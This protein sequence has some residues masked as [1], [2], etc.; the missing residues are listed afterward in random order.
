M[1]RLRG[2]LV[3]FNSIVVAL[4]VATVVIVMSGGNSGE[5][6]RV[7]FEGA[8]GSGPAML[9][10]LAKAT[11]LLFAGLGVSIALRAGLFN[12]GVEGQLLV[13]ALSASVA[14]YAIH[15]L[16]AVVHVALVLAAGAAGGA[17]WAFVPGI[18]KAWRGAHEV[19]V[20]IMMNH[21]AILLT[22]WLVNGPLR[23]ASRITNPNA[24]PRTPMM[25]PTAHL[26]TMPGGS[27]FSAG[28]LIALLCAVLVA[29]LIHGTAPGFEI[30]AVGLGREAAR[31]A[32]ISVGRT[33]I[34]AMCL[35]GGLAGMAG[36]VEAVVV[37]HRFIAQFSPGYGF[38]SIAVALLGGLNSLGV[39]LSS[40]LFGGLYTGAN[41]MEILSGTPRQITGVIQAVVI[42]AAASR[43]FSRRPE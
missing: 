16:P 30:R 5:S 26:W 18:L 4:A 41:T 20:T 29:W 11:P 6:L 23:D 35:S 39:T 10:T 12:I 28:F 2:L 40:I 3:P 25:L 32:G 1:N 24:A 27:D 15:G 34:A 14:G 36:A 38:D 37:H 22:N 33:T 17:L 8:F 43:Y 13:G 19:I 42:L 21:L 31:A 7:L 9:R